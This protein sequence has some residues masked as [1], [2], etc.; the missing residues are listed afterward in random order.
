[1]KTWIDLIS[2]S[3]KDFEKICYEYYYKNK[4]KSNFITHQQIDIGELSIDWTT[5]DPLQAKFTTNP[6]TK[7]DEQ[8]DYGMIDDS[9]T[10]LGIHYFDLNSQVS[11]Q[12]NKYFGFDY[13]GVQVNLQLPGKLTPVHCDRTRT[14]FEKLLPI[15]YSQTVTPERVKKYIIFCDD[16]EI[17][18]T[19]AIGTSYVKWHKGTVIEMPWYMPHATANCSNKLRRLIFVVGITP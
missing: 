18:Q 8:T 10:E 1:M 5:I 17:G 11:K 19:F 12:I 4:S 16:Q 2:N 6:V 14:M 15:S 13:S 7:I 9:S 3:P